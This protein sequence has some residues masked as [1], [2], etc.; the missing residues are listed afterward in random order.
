MQVLIRCVSDGCAPLCSDVRGLESLL[1][2]LRDRWRRPRVPDIT[3]LMRCLRHTVIIYTSEPVCMP[4]SPASCPNAA[5]AAQS[6]ASEHRND[7]PRRVHGPP[8]PQKQPAQRGRI[9]LRVD[10]AQD[11]TPARLPTARPPPVACPP[12][13]PSL[14]PS[15][16]VNGFVYDCYTIIRKSKRLSS[17]K[18]PAGANR[19]V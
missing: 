6:C 7:F 3:S 2:P 5:D 16:P 17:G 10:G 8:A 1:E 15:L 11:F 18:L 19:F 14:L 4:S 12:P 9:L 13:L